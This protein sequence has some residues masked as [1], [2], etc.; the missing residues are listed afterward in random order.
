MA[1]LELL[2]FYKTHI[3]YVPHHPLRWIVIASNYSFP[4]SLNYY[5]NLE[6]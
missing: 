5:E 4:N 3:K 2:K 1:D 6:K